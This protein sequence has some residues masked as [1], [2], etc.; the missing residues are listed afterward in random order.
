MQEM[1][2]FNGSSFQAHIVSG[3]NGVQAV[4]IYNVT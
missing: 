3:I 2:L 4:C 1:I